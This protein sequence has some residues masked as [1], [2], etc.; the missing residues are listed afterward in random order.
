MSSP[1]KFP[2]WNFTFVILEGTKYAAK[3]KSHPLS[4]ISVNAVRYNNDWCHR[5]CSW[6]KLRHRYYG[7]NKPPSYGLVLHFWPSVS[8]KT[9]IINLSLNLIFPFLQNWTNNKTF[10]KFISQTHKLMKILDNIW[11]VF[12]FVG[13]FLF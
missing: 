13:W 10:F 4:Y 12:L 9:K 3:E 7:D 2:P 6:E 5:T 11:E 1:R 8:M